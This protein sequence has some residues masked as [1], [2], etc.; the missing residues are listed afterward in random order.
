MAE[1]AKREQGSHPLVGLLFWVLG[2]DLHE[3]HSR[4]S[5][6]NTAWAVRQLIRRTQLAVG[7]R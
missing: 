4:E 6:T 5:M 1:D 7:A 3:K 2:K